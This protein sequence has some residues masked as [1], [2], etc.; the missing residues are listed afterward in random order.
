MRGERT[1]G[2]RRKL[3]HGKFCLDTRKM[4]FTIRTIEDWDRLPREVVRTPLATNGSR[5]TW[6]DKTLDNLIQGHAL[7]RKLHWMISRGSF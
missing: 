2:K 7:K 4:F 1:K 6:P 3:L 5:L